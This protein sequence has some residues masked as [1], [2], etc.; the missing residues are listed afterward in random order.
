MADTGAP[1]DLP[2]VELAPVEL[3]PVEPA[4]PPDLPILGQGDLHDRLNAIE[5]WIKS[6]A[7]KLAALGS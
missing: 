3:A 6:H 1:S 7:A 2:L 5:L 4:P